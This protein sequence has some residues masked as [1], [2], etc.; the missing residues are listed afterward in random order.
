MTTKPSMVGRKVTVTYLNV[1]GRVEF[2]GKV[3]VDEPTRVLVHVPQDV[4][5]Y[6]NPPFRANKVWFDKNALV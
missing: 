2:T 4:M 5:R 6:R 1:Y 3:L